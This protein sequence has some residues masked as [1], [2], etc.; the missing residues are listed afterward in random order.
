MNTAEH[1]TL[2]EH[3]NM[4]FEAMKHFRTKGIANIPTRSYYKQR[5]KTEE[6]Y[7]V[8]LSYKPERQDVSDV[9]ISSLAP[10]DRRDFFIEEL[11]RRKYGIWVELPSFTR[12]PEETKVTLR[13]KNRL[14]GKVQVL[15]GTH[16]YMLNYV[17]VDIKGSE[18][19]LGYADYYRRDA[20]VL[21]IVE[22][23]QNYELGALEERQWLMYFKS[24]GTHFSTMMRMYIVNQLT[25]RK[26][27]DTIVTIDEDRKVNKTAD[28]IKDYYER[29]P[30]WCREFEPATKTKEPK[31]LF[32]KVPNETDQR[33]YELKY[34]NAEEKTTHP[35]SSS[36]RVRI[37][38]PTAFEEARSNFIFGDEVNLYNPSYCKMPQYEEKARGTL[39]YS[40]NKVEGLMVLGGVSDT[41]NKNLSY[42]KELAENP[43]ASGCFVLF[44]GKQYYMGKPDEYGWTDEEAIIKQIEAR[45]NQIKQS[46]P[47]KYVVY[48]AQNA[49]KLSDCFKITGANYIDIDR[50][51][52][53]LEDVRR[54][55]ANGETTIHRG[56]LRCND[57]D[58]EDV[59]FVPDPYGGWY[60]YEHPDVAMKHQRTPKT[61]YIAGS[62]N[63]DS[64]ITDDEAQSVNE[65]KG[66][67]SQQS[68]VVM[69]TATK[70]VVAMY[71]H[72]SGDPKKDYQQ[73]L[74]ACVYYKCRNLPE[75]NK[76]KEVEYF[77]FES[78]FIDA[79]YAP[80]YFARYLKMTP[81]RATISDSSRKKFGLNTARNKE[82]WFKDYYAPYIED[83]LENIKIPTL[84]EDVAQYEY[85]VG[86]Y[87]PD[88]CMALFMCI[89]HLSDV[90]KLIGTQEAKTS[91]RGCKSIYIPKP[92]YKGNKF[93]YE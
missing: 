63:V 76:P 70:E 66:R 19:G 13:A 58:P 81:R 25:W 34:W 48:V 55:I 17:E 53:Q 11:F 24:R 39:I 87:S 85:A 60:I 21:D 91:R 42:F 1:N 51:N 80:G 26:R 52:A 3:Y 35:Y 44:S 5:F 29:Q 14:A 89:M 36:V 78:D 41:N 64:R 43:E 32:R 69:K 12:L 68:M 38:K 82:R 56:W 23:L 88:S 33:A 92:R 4:G 27:F 8:W 93:V 74:F 15:T 86:G 9:Y 6:E 47:E 75:T 30:L 54:D 22:S 37:P 7:R 73:K 83:Y 79:G 18:T 61:D 90:D 59:E 71:L 57:G 31:S 62:D 65:G 16:Y 50:V 45:S 10:A 67:K 84:L 77:Q 72:R 40:A 49:T 28:H 46:S 20:M 2:I